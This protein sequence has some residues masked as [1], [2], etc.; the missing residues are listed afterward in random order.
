MGL[1]GHGHGH[2]RTI[3]K[4]RHG[5]GTDAT[6]TVTTRSR[7]AKAI[8]LRRAAGI[9]MVKLTNGTDNNTAPGAQVVVGSTVTWTYDVTNTGTVP[10]KNVTVTDSDPCVHPVYQS[11]D[12]NN[13]G[14]LDRARRGSTR[15]RERPSPANTRTPARPAARRHGHRPRNGDFQRR[16]LLLWRIADAG[17]QVGLR[18]HRRQQRRDQGG[19]RGGNQ[20]SEDH[21]DRHQRFGPVRPHRHH[22]RCQRILRLCQPAPRHL[23]GDGSAAHRHWRGGCGDQVN[24]LC[25]R[26]VRW[27]RTTLRTTT[28]TAPS[29]PSTVPSN[30]NLVNSLFKQLA[31]TIG[32]TDGFGWDDQGLVRCPVQRQRS[33]AESAIPTLRSVSSTTISPTSGTE[34][35][36]CC[37]QGSTVYTWT[38]RPL[39]ARTAASPAI[40]SSAIS[41]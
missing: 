10:L 31:T 6:G 25:V 30:S 37:K 17:E 29:A 5:H 28:A 24:D 22:D 32:T 20:G 8:V 34:F 3:H 23:H 33:N 36:C 14:L 18:L 13:N 21:L 26:M 15:P 12:T 11:G 39:P 2:R 16:R 19:R 38:A 35:R 4:H 27:R 40:T 41:S 1:H 9:Q 7:P